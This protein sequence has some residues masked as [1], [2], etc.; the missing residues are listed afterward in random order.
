V[1]QQPQLPTTPGLTW[2]PITVDDLPAWLELVRAIEDADDLAERNDAADL[3]DQLLAGSWKDPAA[4][5]LI[6]IDA[7]G[8]ARAV[9]HVDVRPGDTRRVRAFCWGGV[10]PQWRGRG[11]GR[12][13]LAW[14]EARGRQKI[15]AT[16]KAAPGR[17]LVYAE[18]RLADLRRLVQRAGFTEARWYIDM[19]RPVG[20]GAA[21]PEVPLGEG[22]RLVP[23]EAALSERVRQAHHEA[24]AEHWGSEPRSREDW[25]RASVGG[26]CFRPGWSFVVLDG[27]EVAGYT[28]ASAYEQDWPA[29]GYT[30]GWTD[31]LGVRPA[32]RGRRIAPALLAASM[33]AFAEA[34]MQRADIGV[35]AENA[36]GALRLYTGLG[37]EPQRRSVAYIKDVEG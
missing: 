16:G 20:D 36:S 34:G 10:Y 35:D 32:W 33:R 6:G 7:T 17:L 30:F 18:E 19:S 28:L 27:D 22:L 37:Y 21:A 4:D 25:E 24:F 9:G 13:V 14:Q 11:I 29:M 2:R 3:H 26:R 12:Q 1:D 15:A 5:S 23:Y 8:V 31:L